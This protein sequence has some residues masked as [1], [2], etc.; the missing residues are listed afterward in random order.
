MTTYGMTETCGGCVYDGVPLDG[1]EVRT[2]ADGRIGLRGPV[3]ATGERGPDG[4]VMPVT[5]PDGWLWT[6]DLGEVDDGHLTVLG[7]ADDVIVTGGENVAAEA[8]EDVLRRLPGV[9]D[10]AVVGVDDREWGQRVVAVVVVDGTAP[11]LADVRAHVSAE[12]G[13]HAAP[14]EL[15]LVPS[16]P[17]TALGKVARDQVRALLAG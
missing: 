17:R 16:I 7:R 3:V 15:V 6:S 1:V 14:R 5:D 9:D 4:A 11:E 12:L 10:A 2:G 13:A 8:V